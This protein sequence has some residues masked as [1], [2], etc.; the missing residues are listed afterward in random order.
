MLDE[1]GI[2]GISWRQDG[3]EALARYALGD[4][5]QAERLRAFGHDTGLREIAYLETCNRVEAIF[6]RGEAD[7]RDLRPAVYALLT[8]RSARPGEAERILKAWQGEGACEHLFLVA[9]GLDSAALGETEIVGQVRASR[10]LA[11]EADLIGPGLELLFEEALRVA[12]AVRDRTRLAEGSISLAELAA[13]H[14]LKRHAQ[15]SDEEPQPTA[16]VG[17]SPMTERAA[18]SLEKARVPFVVVNRTLPK[19]REFAGRFGVPCQSLEDFRTDPP[20]VGAILSA[21]GARTPVIGDPFFARL[22]ANGVNRPPLCVDMGVPP[23]IDPAACAKAG[24]RRIGMDDIVEEAECNREARL[25]QAADARELV[26]AALPQLR[27]RL[28]DRLYGALFAKLQAHYQATARTGAERLLKSLRHLDAEDRETISTWTAGQARRFA[29]LPTV[30]IRNL[31]LNGPDGA[32]DAFLDGLDSRLAAEL[33][34]TA[35][36]RF[37]AGALPGRAKVEGGND[38]PQ[39]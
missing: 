34:P 5:D 21:T 26:D 19:A 28:T 11:R 18:L 7:H 23:D 6:L 39:A 27:E 10:D 31:L 25:A 9:A 33:R 37:A 36:R 15:A 20:V 38:D 16:L 2:V 29:H 1:F 3:S 22:A 4:S 30:G 24:A 8:G 32:L 14:I 17:V 12:G 35:A 13:G